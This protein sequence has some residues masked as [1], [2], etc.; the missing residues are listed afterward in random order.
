MN[1][2]SALSFSEITLFGCIVA[3]LLVWA[4]AIKG[5]AL[6]TAARRGDR[7]WFVILLVVNTV[8]VL[9]LAYLRL[10]AKIT[11][12]P[13]DTSVTLKEWQRQEQ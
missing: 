13:E 5:Y 8:G 12:K 3:L 10:V 11:K 4:V 1:N 2:F 9:E 6:W 7:W